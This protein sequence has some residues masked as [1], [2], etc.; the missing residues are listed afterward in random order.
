MVWHFTHAANLGAIVQEG[1]LLSATSIDPVVSV[2]NRGVKE[3]RASVIVDPDG[4]YP[5][6]VV[7]DHVPFYIAAKSPMLYVVDRGHPDYEGGC[8]ELVFFGVA[9]GDLA[10]EGVVWCASDQNAST[11]RVAFSRDLTSLGSFVDFDLLCRRLWRNT[12]DDPDRM[13][14]RAAEVLVLDRVPLEMVRV[15]VTKNEMTLAR[16]HGAL[17][18]V[19]GERQYHVVRDLFY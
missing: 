14:R 7:S 11:Q 8:D 5:E 3:R 19:G 6:S 1:A 12:P 17:Q 9:L 2:A 15:V 16:A 4:A 18:T 10:D 13:S